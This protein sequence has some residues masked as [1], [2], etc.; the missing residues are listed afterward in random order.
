MNK[1]EKYTATLREIEVRLEKGGNLFS[2]IGNSLAVI[3]KRFEH[4]WLGVYLLQDRQLVL[5]PFQG[6]P[7]CVFLSLDAGVCAACVREKRSIIVPDVTVFPGH[8]ACDPRSRSELVV[9]L[10]DRNARIRGVLDVDS[11]KADAF[12]EID[13]EGLEKVGCLLQPLWEPV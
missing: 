5:G 8:V 1:Q 2:D 12:D 11:D 7:A 9:P 3:G 6:P 10:F 13:R 4:F